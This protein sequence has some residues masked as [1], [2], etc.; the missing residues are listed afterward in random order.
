VFGRS[1]RIVEP[2]YFA[3]ARPAAPAP[4]TATRLAEMEI[5]GGSEPIGLL[6]TRWRVFLSRFILEQNGMKVLTCCPTRG[7]T[8]RYGDTIGYGDILNS[9]VESHSHRG[10]QVRL[11]QY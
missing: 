9:N 7:L 8:T 6:I 4:I 11:N 3:A 2:M 10:Y 1:R 5:L